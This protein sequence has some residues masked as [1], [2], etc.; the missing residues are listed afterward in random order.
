MQQHNAARSRQA[1][2]SSAGGAGA[3]LTQLRAHA[4]LL[5][6]LG[7]RIWCLHRGDA[8][9]AQT[10]FYHSGSLLI[11]VLACFLCNLLLAQAQEVTVCI[12]SMHY[13]SSATET[14]ISTCLFNLNT[15]EGRW[16]ASHLLHT[17]KRHLSPLHPFF[18]TVKGESGPLLAKVEG[19]CA[20]KVYTM[21]A[22]WLLVQIIN[23]FI[24]S[25]LQQ[26]TNSSRKHH[27]QYL[28]CHS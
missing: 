6:S 18:H 4:P 17:C 28:G 10:A 8:H 19:P 2:L 16:I 24:K 3:S 20:I 12:L 25:A 14:G 26:R 5:Q 23:A 13:V 11:T 1:S 7:T 22:N 15:S 27:N 9:S 21:T